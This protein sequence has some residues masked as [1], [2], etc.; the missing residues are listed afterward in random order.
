MSPNAWHEVTYE[1]DCANDV[2]H[3]ACN[4]CASDEELA[5]DVFLLSACGITSVMRKRIAAGLATIALSLCPT[6]AHADLVPPGGEGVNACQNKKAGD[7]CQN[8][9]IREGGQNLEDGT[10][11]E[12]KLDH[13]RF[14]FKAHL[15]CVSASVPT[16]KASAAPSASATPL[17]VPTPSTAPIAL[18]AAPQPP[19]PVPS[20]APAEPA[21]SGGC[22]WTNEGASSAG[23]GVFLFGLIVLVGA[24]RLER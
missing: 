12:E 23:L 16:P 15:R 21:K 5:E 2:T 13:L 4:V 17:P 18:S 7:K 24:R 11:V 8:Y 14:K 19:A 1:A 3:R 22:S 6:L 9:I 10:C 20:A